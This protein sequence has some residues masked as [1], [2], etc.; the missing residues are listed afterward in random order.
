VLVEQAGTYDDAVI[1]VFE[2]A[3][4]LP[5]VGPLAIEAMPLTGYILVLA[6]RMGLTDQQARRLSL[7][8]LRQLAEEGSR[9]A[10]TVEEEASLR[11]LLWFKEYDRLP[12]TERAKRTMVFVAAT[13]LLAN[14]A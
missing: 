3:K 8:D 5:Y 14:L 12:D 13:D 7:D 2:H 4:T 6:N 10:D 11:I 1:A 9:S